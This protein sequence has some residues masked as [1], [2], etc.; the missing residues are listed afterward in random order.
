MKEKLKTKQDDESMKLFG[1]FDYC[2]KY[3]PLSVLQVVVCF[4]YII[5][6]WD[7]ALVA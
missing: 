5:Y 7:G 1:Y 2:T 6:G 3:F 4:F